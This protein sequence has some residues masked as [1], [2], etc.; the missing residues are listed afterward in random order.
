MSTGSHLHIENLGVHYR[1]RTVLSGVDLPDIRPGELIAL[2]GPNAAGKSTLLRAIAGLVP[3]SGQV[4]YGDDNW[5][6]WSAG[7]RVAHIGY[8]P[9]AST[10]SSNLTVLEATLVA[11][12]WG[13]TGARKDDA[14]TAL[15]VIE[16]LGIGELAL[17]ALHELSGGQRQLAALAQ[18]V[19]RG[20]SILLLDEPVSA[21]DLAHQ[22]QVMNVARRLANEGRIVIVVLHDL[23]LAAQ[24]ADRIAILHQRRIH[25]FGHPNTIITDT[26]L[27]DVWGVQARVRTF[28]QGR[29]FV[30]V[31]AVATGM[32][33]SA[34]KQ[35][36]DNS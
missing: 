29:P 33:L 30:L 31:D 9:Q 27:R 26:L 21:L 10:E 1:Q 18:A 25:A 20:S 5:S 23:A 13:R 32:D 15:R 12:Q 34:D 14:F 19:V 7:K 35:S 11:L 36:Q 16:H 8:M 17:R 2:A 3:A 22:W 24:W 6:G 28:E 4:R